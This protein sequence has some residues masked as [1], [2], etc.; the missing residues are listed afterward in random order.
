MLEAARYTDLL[1][2]FSINTSEYWRKHYQFLKPMPAE[3]PS[4]GETSVANIMINTTVPLMVCYG[5]MRDDQY[6]VDRALAILQHVPAEDNVIIK[7]WE[8]LGFRAKNAADSQGLIE[9][10]NALCMKRRCLDCSIGFS[11]L[12]PA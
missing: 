2:L 11:L 4:F 12:Q 6:L 1:K 5:K 8:D 10:H 3:I 9:L 7:T